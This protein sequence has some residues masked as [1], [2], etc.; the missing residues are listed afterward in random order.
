MLLLYSNCSMPTSLW[1]KIKTYMSYRSDSQLPFS[2]QLPFLLCHKYSRH[3]HLKASALDS[4]A[5]NV[6]S[7]NSYVV[8]PL[9]SFRSL[10]N[11]T[12]PESHSLFY[13]LRD[14]RLWWIKLTSSSEKKWK[15]INVHS[16][17]FVI[18]SNWKQPTRTSMSD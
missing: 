10:L 13:L 6:L 17:L 12:L 16:S 8:F 2:A 18:P 7:P 15:Q 5:W 9:G 3:S 4:S 11:V 1:E 14:G